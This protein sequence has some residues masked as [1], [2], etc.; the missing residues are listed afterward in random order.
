LLDVQNEHLV[1]EIYD[2]V[3]TIVA[4][5]FPTSKV[6]QNHAHH[7]LCHQLISSKDVV[8]GMH[9]MIFWYAV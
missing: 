3:W 2:M 5:V 1:P 6:Y 4:M 9:P 7:F 8:D